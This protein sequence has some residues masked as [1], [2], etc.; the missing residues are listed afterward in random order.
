[1]AVLSYKCPN[2]D[3]ELKFDP[4]S[5]Q[6]ACE[7][8]GSSFSQQE[9]E[10]LQPAKE[11]EHTAPEE[12]GA[13]IY[14]CP[15]CGAEI[16]TD[17]TTAAT[18]CF[19]CHNPVVLSGRL[20]GELMPD[21][22]I[23]FA[24]DKEQAVK[25]FLDYVGKKR[26]VPKAFFNKKQIEKLSGVYFPHWMCSWSGNGEMKAEGSKV[27]VWRS[28]NTEYTETKYYD[29]YRRGD[30]AFRDIS[31]NALKKAEHELVNGVQPFDMEGAKE[32]SMGYLSGFQAEKRDRERA[33]FETE[34]S[35]EVHRYAERILRDSAAEYTSL[36][37]VHTDIAKEK[38]NFNW[39][40]A[41]LPVWVLTYRAANGKFFYYAMNG[42]N[43][44]TYGELPVDYRKVAVTSAIAGAA[45]MV[46]G[47]LGGFLL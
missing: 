43:G 21:S 35:N 14:T 12:S 17:D 30:I 40:Y 41:L 46:L 34:V 27:R 28:G 2:C 31:K 3:G 11:Q 20:S 7:Y 38:E 26:F 32:F 42:Q 37:T 8:C 29:V 4:E 25:K 15:S 19:Y 24:Y 45:I 6:Y 10:K 9:F 23:P 33:E 39:K 44:K 16:V 5:Q 13:V 22:V 47:L 1:M 36:R 18:F